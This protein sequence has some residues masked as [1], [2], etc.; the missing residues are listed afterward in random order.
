MD[1]INKQ[2]PEDTQKPLQGKE[3]ADKIRELAE[4]AKTCFFCTDLRSGSSFKTRPMSVQKIDDQ[5]SLWFLSASDSRKDQDINT[6]PSVQLFF[7]GSAHS[8][9]LTI[10]G[11]ATVSRD[12]AKIDELWEPLMK[13]WFTEGKDDPRI[14]VIQVTPSES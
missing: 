9:F 7:Q 3:A 14:S 8:D 12:K 13:T 2:Q 10:Y 4:K 5:G 1:S 6:D 11:M